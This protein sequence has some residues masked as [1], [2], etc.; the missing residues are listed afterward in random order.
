MNPR[1]LEILKLLQAGEKWGPQEL[2]KRMGV[3]RRTIYRDM[4]KLRAEGH[5]IHFDEEANTYA[6]NADPTSPSLPRG[7]VASIPQRLNKEHLSPEEEDECDRIIAKATRQLRALK[8]NHQKHMSPE[9]Q[10]LPGIRTLRQVGWSGVLP[11][12]DTE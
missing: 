8:I 11:V 5:D 12:F 6:I 4:D 2:A 1:T 7:K 10:Y 3:S 9:T